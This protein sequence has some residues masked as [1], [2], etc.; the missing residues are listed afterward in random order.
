MDTDVA[1]KIVE[2]SRDAQAQ[3]RNLLRASD[4]L[5]THGASAYLAIQV[6]GK[7]VMLELTAAQA[8]NAVKALT[9]ANN[10][11]LRRLATAMDAWTEPAA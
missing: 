3:K 7:T 1:Q 9:T 5:K 11:L 4:A 6:N 2:Q 10:A 8:T